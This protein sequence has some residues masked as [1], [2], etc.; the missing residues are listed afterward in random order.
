ME[1]VT[2]YN[3][4]NSLTPFTPTPIDVTT[5]IVGGISENSYDMW[6]F[7]FTTTRTITA[8]GEIIVKYAGSDLG[9]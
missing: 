4:A 9:S 1:S 7:K 2:T 8:G 5:L 3:D 6:E